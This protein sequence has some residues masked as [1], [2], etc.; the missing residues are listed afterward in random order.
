MK[1]DIGDLIIFNYYYSI[2]PNMSAVSSVQTRCHT[3][4]NI[5]SQTA[6]PRKAIVMAIDSRDN[7]A[8]VFL[9]NNDNRLKE[10]S[11]YGKDIIKVICPYNKLIE[12]L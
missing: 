8:T 3:T 2:V 7:S 6:V 11:V 12:G 5:S 10:Y 1:F 4:S 9:S